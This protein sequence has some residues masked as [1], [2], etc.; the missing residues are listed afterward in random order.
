MAAL[1]G[2]NMAILL[3]QGIEQS[4]DYNAVREVALSIIAAALPFQAIYFLI[5]TFI[6]EHEAQLSS[7]RLHKL[8]L[9]SALCQVVS[10]ASLIGVAVMWYETS[11]WVGLSFTLSS[12]LALFLIRAV[13][14]PVKE[15]V[16]SEA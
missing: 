1:L 9:A 3:F 2:T 10:Y 12:V 11:A 13:M 7:G 15:T 14:G 8:G 5:Y 6:L 4:R 16:M